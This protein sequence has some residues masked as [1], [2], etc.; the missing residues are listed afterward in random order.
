[1]IINQRSSSE[2]IEH[3]SLATH[4]E[5]CAHRIDSINKRI[6]DIE[7]RQDKIDLALTSLKYFIIKSVS[8]ATALIASTVSLTVIV[9][10]RLQ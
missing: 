5:L 9:L 4:V 7:R 6:D 8:V 1:M 2:N 10:D 3:E